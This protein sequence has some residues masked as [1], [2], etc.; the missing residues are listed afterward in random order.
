M[1]S[2]DLISDPHFNGLSLEAQN[3]FLRMLSVSDDCGVV[4]INEYR[5][6]TIINTPDR[7]K[8][9]IRVIVDEIVSAGLG[10]VFQYSSDDFFAFKSKSFEEYQSYILKKATKSEYLRIPTDEFRELSKSFLE[11][12]GNSGNISKSALAQYKDISIKQRVESKEIKD[13][14]KQKFLD[15]VWLTI[16]E[17][18]A[19]EKKLGSKAN[20]MRAIEILDNY[21]GSSGKKYKS[22][23]KA[24]LTWVVSELEKRIQSGSIKTTN[25]KTWKCKYCHAEMP[26]GKQYEHWNVCEKMKPASP[27]TVAKTKKE[28]SNLMG[29]MNVNG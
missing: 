17:F 18:D 28:V 11:I 27:E 20:V 2:A 24:I 6:N 4:P 21:K 7:L 1:I 25:I 19:L 10:N 29:K 23:Y 14:E 16:E 13:K 15:D 8:K 5:L 22:D 12:L 9:K 3:V 26:E